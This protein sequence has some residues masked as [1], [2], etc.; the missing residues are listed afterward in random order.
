VA[1]LE[2]GRSGAVDPAFDE[3]ALGLTDGL[4]DTV[5][6]VGSD[7]LPEE[8]NL[9]AGRM[10]DWGGV[11]GSQDGVQH[12]DGMVKVS[13]SFCSRATSQRPTIGSVV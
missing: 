11:G 3:G 7:S 1:A 10:V 6:F 13:G 5:G 12:P 2:E 8:G 4:G 9:I